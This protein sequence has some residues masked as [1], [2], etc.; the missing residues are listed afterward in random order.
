MDCLILEER[1]VSRNFVGGGVQK[2][3]LRAED[4]DLG[5]AAP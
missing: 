1:G 5:A 2:I 3:Q 4:R